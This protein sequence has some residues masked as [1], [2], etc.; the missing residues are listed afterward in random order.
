MNHLAETIRRI[1][2]I[3][4][5]HYCLECGK[6]TSI[7]PVARRDGASPRLLVDKALW[8]GVNELL[9]DEFLWD[10]LTCASCTI[11]C[12]SN[13]A[14]IEFVRDVRRLARE[15]GQEGLCAHGEVIQVWM[16]LMA[17]G[18][19]RQKRLDWL[20]GDLRLSPRSDTIYFV[21]CLPYY[22]ALFGELG[23]RGG[24]LARSVVRILNHLGLEPQV[25]ADERCC[26]HDLL[27]AGDEEG[28]RRLAELNLALFQDSGAR[29]IITACPECARTLKVD[30]PAYG[31]D[32]GM[33]VLHLAEFLA[34]ALE[35]GER[36]LGRMEGKVT[37]HDPCRLGRHLGVYQ[38]PRKV[39]AALGLELVE[40]AH[41]GPG[42]LCCGTSLWTNCGSISR[43]I[44]ADRLREA[45]ETGARLLVTACPK[46]QIHLRCALKDR[47]PGPRPDIEIC[48]LAVLVAR[49]LESEVRAGSNA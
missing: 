30:Y 17:R 44:Q 24:E 48:D 8:G 7:C 2:A 42:A 3:T 5:A 47:E 43:A 28:F 10:C 45:E 49:S 16:R 19:L 37:Y 18:E 46:C 23:M 38:E 22:D 29:R 33:E 34:Q 40:M 26:G 21:G 1:I 14:F 15:E 25:L 32:H 36:T 35:A 20:E 4:G 13:V 39:L 27:W 6:C 31:F 9:K 12:P 11:R 41:S